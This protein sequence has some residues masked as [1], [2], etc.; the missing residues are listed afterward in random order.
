MSERHQQHDNQCSCSAAADPDHFA[1]RRNARACLRCLSARTGGSAAI[2]LVHLVALPPG[3]QLTTAGE[4]KGT[5]TGSGTYS[6]NFTLSDSQGTPS[7][8]RE[9]VADDRAAARAPPLITTTS[10]PDGT[11]GRAYPATQLQ[12]SGGLAPY[13]WTLTSGSLPPGLLTEH[14]RRYLG[15]SEGYRIHRQQDF[16]FHRAGDGRQQSNGHREPVDH[17]ARRRGQ[18]NRNQS[19]VANRPLCPSILGQGGRCLDSSSRGE[20][21]PAQCI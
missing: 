1:S 10:L 16:V 17:G 4:I 19:Q 13:R 15:H 18:R 3:L 9:A 6:L 5:P 20:H 7:A 2:P 14:S 8:T 12:A 11:V 21:Q